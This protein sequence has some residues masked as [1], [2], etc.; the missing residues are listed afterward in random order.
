MSAA[1]LASASFIY[2]NEIMIKLHCCFK[3]EKRIKMVLTCDEAKQ[4]AKNEMEKLFEKV[5]FAKDFHHGK[6]TD[7]SY[8][9]RHLIE[10]ILRIRLNN[11][12]DAYCLYKIPHTEHKLAMSLAQYLA[13]E[14]GH[15]NF[16]KNDLKTFGTSEDE[17]NK[18]KV[19][20]AT[21]KLIGYL[22]CC[23]NQN[24]PLITMV[25][26]WFVEW[27]SDTY[28]RIITEKATVDLGKKHTQGFTKH[29]DFDEGHDHIGLMFSTV[30]LAIKNEEDAERA[31]VYLT[32]LISL[33]G[34]YFQ[35]LYD[36]TL[37]DK[38]E[39]K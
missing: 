39:T 30:E 11:E 18:T 21:E 38:L 3:I 20:F 16:F 29:I 31:K 23:I 22:Y 9:V 17:L 25:W 33:I 35:E 2:Y 34:D 4:H 6:L 24:G 14:L 12:A 10:T 32:N 8:Y 19:F 37:K 26:N 5:P 1:F 28:N 7:R 27:Y 36:L 15:E 13:E